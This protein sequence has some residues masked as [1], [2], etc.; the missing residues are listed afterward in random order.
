[1]GEKLE[2]KIKL[3]CDWNA[4]ALQAEQQALCEDHRG[5]RTAH[6]SSFFP[7]KEQSPDKSIYSLVEKSKLFFCG[8]E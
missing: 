2:L 4:A 8:G 3:G 5:N 7:L 1:M 6:F